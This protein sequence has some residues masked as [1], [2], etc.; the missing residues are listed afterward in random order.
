MGKKTARRLAGSAGYFSDWR[1]KERVMRI[2]KFFARL[3]AVAII[4]SAAA[5]IIAMTINN[6]VVNK[7]KENIVYAINED[8][9]TLMSSEIDNP[10]R[11]RRGLH[12]R[13]RSRHKG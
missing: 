12:P 10:Q 1:R 6:H 3:L 13:V 4:L 9:E 2:R 5:G 7:E 8:K 11:F